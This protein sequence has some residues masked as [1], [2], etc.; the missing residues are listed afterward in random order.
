MS[1]GEIEGNKPHILIQ[2]TINKDNHRNLRT[3]DIDGASPKVMGLKR[4]I[5]HDDGERK[6]NSNRVNE[7]IQAVRNGQYVTNGYKNK[8]YKRFLLEGELKQQEEA[9]ERNE[10]EHQKPVEGR[11]YQTEYGSTY[12]HEIA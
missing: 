7:Q 4:I 5:E 2:Q 10:S 9:A 11:D 8:A 1:Y 12:H 6:Y 3:E